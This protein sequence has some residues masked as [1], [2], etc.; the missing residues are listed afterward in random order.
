MKILSALLISVGIAFT[1]PALADEYEPPNNGHPDGTIGSG[2][3]A[4][5]CHRGGERRENC[6]QI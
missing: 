1:S 3:R 4:I 5:D 6:S 2:T